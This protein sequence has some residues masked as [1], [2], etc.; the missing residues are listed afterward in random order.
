MHEL[1]CVAGLPNGASVDAPDQQEKNTAKVAL[2]DLFKDVWLAEEEEEDVE[3]AQHAQH[4]Q[5]P[6]DTEVSRSGGV[7]CFVDPGHNEHWQGQKCR[8][9]YFGRLL[10]EQ[11]SGNQHTEQSQGFKCG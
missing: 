7:I 2:E 8:C 3:L 10:Y 6:P 1:A 9:H 11:E 4:A 5:H